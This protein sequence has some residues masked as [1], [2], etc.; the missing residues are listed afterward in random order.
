MFGATALTFSQLALEV[1]VAPSFPVEIDTVTNQKRRTDTGR[2]RTR[3]TAHHVFK[4]SITKDYLKQ[5]L[6]FFF[7]GQCGFVHDPR[8]DEERKDPG[9]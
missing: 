5:R 6:F 3:P 2:Y 4:Q 9:Q 1:W 7:L 8:I